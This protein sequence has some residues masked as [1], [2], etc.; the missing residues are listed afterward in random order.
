MT[1]K[2]FIALA[3]VSSREQEREGFSLDIQVDAL[4][5][6]AERRKGKIIKL[7]RIAETASKKDERKTF[8][9]LIAFAK[10]HAADLD[11]ILFYKIDRAAR[12]LFDYVELER[13]ESEF[14]V[15]FFS[16]TQPTENT[17]AGRMQRRML[18][19]MASFY[20]EQQSLDV[21]GGVKRRVEEG[22]FPQKAPY[23]YRNIRVEKRG[24]VEIH[25]VNGPKVTKLFELY[26]YHNLTLDQLLERLYHDGIHYTESVPRFPRSTLYKILRDRSYIGEILYEGQWRPGT[27]KHLVDRG[28]WNRVQALLG[29][30]VYR[31]H[32]LTYAGGLIQCK[33]CGGTITGESVTKKSTGKEYVYYRC[34]LYNTPGHPRVRLNEEK[35]DRQ[36]L[37][38]YD[39]MRLNSDEERAWFVEE[40]SNRTDHE[41]AQA[42]I[43]AEEIQRQLSLLR[44]QQDRL[45]NLRLLG[46]IEEATMSEKAT[47][48]RDR[49]ANF[50]LQ[51]DACDLGRHENAE[52]AIKAFELS[53]NLRAKWLTADY[54]EKRRVLEI[55]FLNFVLDDVTLVPETRKPFD[56]LAEGPLVLSSR[57]DRI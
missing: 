15:P 52:I 51:L 48:L 37:A 53:Q 55:V 50:K 32:E 35:L 54:A 10:R 38:L 36:L 43:K 8:K 24:L 21:K 18:A 40:L 29:E 45:L 1:K 11:G 9:E 26:A 12:N 57:G 5:L 19:S 13:L 33:H 6:D 30:K 22:L 20:T 4:N 28:T 34:S 46:E 23:G 49:E 16:V 7:W 25:P 2:R 47:E 41:Q 17:P 31:S 44:Q 39:K 14:D 27:H 3:R 42:R 56:M